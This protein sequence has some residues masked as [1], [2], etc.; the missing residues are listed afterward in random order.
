MLALIFEQRRCTDNHKVWVHHLESSGKEAFVAQLV[1]WMNTEMKS[2]MRATAPLRNMSQPTR[3]PVGHFGLDLNSSKTYLPHKCWL[4][5]NSKHWTDQCQ[6]FASL[7][8]EMRVKAVRENHACFSCLK[9][10]GREHRSL[11]CSRRR[12]C[13]Q[14]TNGSQCPYYHHLLLH[15]T[16]QPT[17]A[18]VTYVT[19]NQKALLPIVQVDIIGSGSLHQ[20]AN[21]LLDSGAQISLI[22]SCVAENLK[23]KGKSIV[24]TIAKVGSQEE[25]LSTK[26]YQVR[27]RSLEDCS[28]HVIQAIG[29]PSISDYS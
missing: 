12:Q 3:Y 13:P 26:I 22:R 23:L 16:I 1:A 25:E 4:C 17:V 21:A 20:R 2:R 24:V 19:N 18:T 9:L 27:I 10:A 29:I 15:G 28:A 7:S 11:N 5:H 6:K 8:P 14:K